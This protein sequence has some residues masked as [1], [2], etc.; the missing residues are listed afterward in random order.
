MLFSDIFRILGNYLFCFA[1]ILCIPLGV[2]IYFEY[3]TP[4]SHRYFQPPATMAFFETI[5]ICLVI[6]FLCRLSGRKARGFIYRRESIVLVILIWIATCLISAFPFY[7]SKTLE[8]VDSLFE[9]MSGLTT[10]GATMLA[11]KNYE[12]E[13]HKE[14]PNISSDPLLPGI[15]YRSNGTI[16]PVFDE[17]TKEELVGLDA[18]S[19]AILFWRSFLQ[20]MGGMGIVVLFLTVLPALG[21]GGKF[22]YQT[23][24]TGPVKDA[25]APRIK[26]T[27]SKLWKLYLGLTVLEVILLIWTNEKMPVF[28][29]LC[30]SLSNISTGGFTIRNSGIAGYH[31]SATEWIVIAF[32]I[33]G[34]I[35]FAFYFYILRLKL[36]KLYTPD[37]FLF[38]FCIVAGS[39]LIA[40]YIYGTPSMEVESTFATYSVKDAIR[41]GAFQAVSSQTSTG[42]STANYDLWPF[43]AQMFMLLLMF[44]G[45]MSGSTGGGIKTSRFYILYK[46]ITHRIESL[47][48]P[49]SVR[50][51]IIKKV[52]I[53]SKTSTLVLG[54]FCIVVFFTVMGTVML[55]LDG[56]DPET[57]FGLLVSFLN[58]VGMA[59]AAAGPS[60]TINYLSPFSKIFACFWMLLGRLEYYAIL[61]LFFPGFWKGK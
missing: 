56:I 8:P 24:L 60:D 29:A 1:I 17:N 54:F 4:E 49:E 48:R 28:D 10:T 22:L 46:I 7:L 19:R 18:V 51:L 25:I 43:P 9:S 33:L 5:L 52:E 59:F 39:G 47:F 30:I 20:W 40:Y 45:G 12:P 31:S 26:E 32:M 50:K 42:F 53:D 27:A 38:I 14:I 36:Y 58:N 37:F 3:V 15:A 16:P 23:E 44:V 6:A 57:S 41:S 61:L 35:N 34:S 13:T 55:I 21:V 2:S 11:P